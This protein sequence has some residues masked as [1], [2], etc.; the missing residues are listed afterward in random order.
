LAV[1][2]DQTPWARDEYY[3]SYNSTD[4][5]IE[6]ARKFLVRCWQ[7]YATRTGGKTGWRHSAA[8][9]C[10]NMPEQWDKVPGRVFE[11]ATRLK[12]AQIENKDAIELIEKYNHPDVFIYADP[13]YV[14]NT[15]ASKIYACEIDDDYHMRMLNALKKHQGN[16]I[17]SGYDNEL[18]NEHLS[19]WHIEHKKASVENGATRIETIWMNYDPNQ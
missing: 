18:Y 11:V 6:K 17:I 15:R 1:L 19:N 4:D 7:A 13:P 2:I 9:L 8:G 14:T 3:D 12:H 5:P 16:V 10:P